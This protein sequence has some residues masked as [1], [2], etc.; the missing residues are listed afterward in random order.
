M[1]DH[2]SVSS[3]PPLTAAAS[4]RRITARRTVL[5][6]GATG[7]IIGLVAGPEFFSSDARGTGEETWPDIA[8]VSTAED[9]EL[10]PPSQWGSAAFDEVLAAVDHL[11]PPGSPIR[12]RIMAANLLISRMD[13]GGRTPVTEWSDYLQSGLRNGSCGRRAMLLAG[14]I[15]HWDPA[16]P[17][18]FAGMASVPGQASHTTLEVRLPETNQWSWFDPSSGVIFTEDGTLDGRILSQNEAFADPSIVD[19]IGPLAPRGPRVEGPPRRVRLD[20]PL[21]EHLAT[22]PGFSRPNFPLRRML[23]LSTAWG[24]GDP[25]EPRPGRVQ[26]HVEDS[27]R[28]EA[29]RIREDGSIER[30]VLRDDE[31]RLTWHDRAGVSSSGINVVP[32]IAI[33][34]L[35]PGEHVELIVRAVPRHRDIRLRPFVSDGARL[36]RATLTEG[37]ERAGR[38]S[39]VVLSMHLVAHAERAVVSILHGGDERNEHAVV[40]SYE[41]R[42]IA[43]PPA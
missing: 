28:I 41:V 31:R 9:R 16:I 21:S 14:V 20:P 2:A 6:A 26:L 1:P 8:A 42:R 11:M 10:R 27:S 33:D 5:V 32:V 34:G 39:V 17:V 7:V 23:E 43:P 35:M 4:A 22:D 29:A 30:L 12:D 40:L 38:D 24:S 37:T 15:R 18:R 13:N 19:R 36:A 3:P 25:L